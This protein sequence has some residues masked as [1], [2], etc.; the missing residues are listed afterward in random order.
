VLAALLDLAGE[1]AQAVAV[2]P[3]PAIDESWAEPMVFG[4]C[5]TEGQA[6]PGPAATDPDRQKVRPH[7]SQGAQA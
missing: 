2:A 3:E 6:R 1:R 5:S 7:P 4:G